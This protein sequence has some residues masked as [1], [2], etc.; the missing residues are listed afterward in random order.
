V[1]YYLRVFCRSE[2]RPALREVVAWL[3][4]HGI[5]VRVHSANLDAHGSQQAELECVPRQPPVLAELND[6]ESLREEVSEFLELLEDDEE[7]EEKRAVLRHLAASTFVVAVRLN[8]IDDETNTAV[9]GFLTYFRDH[10]DGLI[11]ADGEG[12]YF[13]DRLAV[14]VD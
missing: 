12:F 4:P 11:Q 1:S 13:G 8:E 9:G 3:T 2:D 7:S 6:G 5:T 14:Q 10:C